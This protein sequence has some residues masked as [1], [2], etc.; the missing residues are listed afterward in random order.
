MSNNYGLKIELVADS[1]VGDALIS[2]VSRIF[3]WPSATRFFAPGTYTVEFSTDR[4]LLTLS[5]AADRDKVAYE[6]EAVLSDEDDALRL[7]NAI[8]GLFP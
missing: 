4:G 7:R 6:L 3:G 8:V 1:G 5:A 2:C